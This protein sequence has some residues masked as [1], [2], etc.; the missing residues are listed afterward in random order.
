[1]DDVCAWAVLK[2]EGRLLGQKVVPQPR[3]W[4]AEL[5]GCQ[6]KLEGGISDVTQSGKEDLT[7]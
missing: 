1:V 2:G 3:V 4:N 6:K 7:C 5:E